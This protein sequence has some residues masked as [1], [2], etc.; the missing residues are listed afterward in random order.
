MTRGGRHRLVVLAGLW[1]VAGA[2]A[3]AQ[4]A[5]TPPSSLQEGTPAAAAEREAFLDLARTAEL[6]LVLV[7]ELRRKNAALT[8][9]VAELTDLLDIERQTTTEMRL[10]QQQLSALLGEADRTGNETSRRLASM[11]E[12][13]SRLARRVKEFED[14]ATAER[15]IAAAA[16]SQIEILNGQIGALRRQIADIDAALKLSKSKETES[17]VTIAEL[18]RRLNAAL[19]QKVEELARY[20]SEF[21]G[22]LRE[23][24]GDRQD[25]RVVGDRFVFQSEVLFAP[26][27]AELGE[28]ARRQLD[29]LARALSDIAGKIPRDLDWILRVDGHT[30]TV[31][32]RS[33]EFPSNWELST[34]RALAVTKYLIGQGVPPVRVAAA[35]FGEYHPLDPR[36]DEIGFRRNRRIEF[37]LTEK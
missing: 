14:R 30:D 16:Q 10:A 27:S 36:A 19:A 33:R 11:E 24:L 6:V 21:F 20:R 25:M 35:G 34:A 15:R 18:G 7:E 4:T 5:V 2:G 31:P 32:I 28:S 26:G 17:Q 23:S 13:A 1:W 9:R 37:K 12:E 29:A 3:M 22:R 8:T